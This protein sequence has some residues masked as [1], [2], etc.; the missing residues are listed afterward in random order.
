MTRQQRTIPRQCEFCGTPFLVRNQDVKVGKGRFCSKSCAAK[1]RHALLG[2][3]GQIRHVDGYI[4]IYVPEHPDADQ[5]GYVLEH[6]LVA[7]RIL[8]RRLAPNEIV[9]HGNGI[10][11]DNREENLSVMTQAE[12]VALHNVARGEERNGKYERCRDCLRS[13]RPHS[14][15]GLCH[16]CYER[17]RRNR[18]IHPCH[19]AMEQ[20]QHRQ[21]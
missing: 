15:L 7:E 4:Y 8:G 17:R 3:M 16:A 13:D 21:E 19:Q 6:R 10:R 11:S 9:H 14:A 12:H 18:I 1:S 5:I 20:G 2:H